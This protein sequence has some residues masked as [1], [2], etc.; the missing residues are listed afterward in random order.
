MLRNAVLVSFLM[1]LFVG[2]SQT[3]AAADPA[4]AQ[5]WVTYGNQLMTAKQYDKAL[6]AF[7][8]AARADS[9]SA[10]AWKGLG[11]VYYYKKDYAN[12]AKYYKY[13][14]QLNPADTALGAFIPK[15]A[16]A[17]AAAP[18][19]SSATA[20]A[21]RFYQAK[22]YDEAIQYYNQALASNPNDSKAWQGLGNCYYA[23]QDKVKA[24]DAYKRALQLDPSNMALSN[25]LTAYAPESSGAGAVAV[26][27]GPKDWVQPLWR[28]AVLPGWG[29]VYEGRN[30]AGYV[31]G[32]ATLAFLG[33]TVITYIMGD[34]AYQQY[35]SLTDSTADFDT[36]YN[37][38]DSMATLNH[39]FYIAFGLTYTYTLVDAVMNAKP[40]PT[41][42]AQFNEEAP[43]LQLSMLDRDGA[44][45]LKYRLLKF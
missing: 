23:K 11:T 36:P 42:H 19:S 6:Q 33:G 37:T 27:G 28:S 17:T 29:Q 31:L 20:Y 4:L 44:M 40:M 10:A 7:T 34:A 15:L 24:V 41:Q 3:A 18:A 25:F 38:W 45:G 26:A 9:R 35:M 13:S 32:G 43:A 30:T 5:K 12:A 39:I 14:Y 8:T 2:V 21:A 22:R 16:A 1:T